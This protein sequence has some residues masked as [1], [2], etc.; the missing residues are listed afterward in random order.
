M[1]Y[2][3]LWLLGRVILGGYF[4][5][6]AYNHF[7]NLNGM[8]GYAASKGM[9]MPKAAVV[10]SGLM[11]LLGGLGILIGVYVE[12]SI[13]LLVLFL[14][15]T[16]IKMHVYWK[17]TDPM[18]RMVERVNFYKNLG[19]IGSL[20]MITPYVTPLGDMIMSLFSF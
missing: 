13:Y 9:P 10:I 7:K 8:T 15:G 3:Y 11:L 5:Q 14:L 19:L 17:E 6:N 16:L 1:E 2:S 20:L 4:I 12:Y 18:A